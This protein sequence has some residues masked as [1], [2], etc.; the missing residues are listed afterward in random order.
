MA[1]QKDYYDILGVS[2]DADDATIKKAYRQ[3]SKKYHPDLNH[4]EGAEEKFKDI[5]EA[6][7]V[8]SDPQKRAAYD[9]YGSADGPQGFGGGQGFSDFGG[10]GQN[11]G[12]FEDIFSSFFGGGGTQQSAAGPRQ[13]ADLQYRM[14]LKFEE[15]IFGKD[16][17]ISYDREATCHTCGGTGAAP[18]TSPVTC[19]KCHGAGYIQVQRNTPLG[20]MMTREVCDVC[21]GTGKEIKDKCPTCHGTGHEQ[22]RHE[23]DVK[24]PAG[25]EDGQQMRL[26]NAGEAGSNGG[27]YGDL[28]IVFRVAPSDK[29]ERDGATIYLKFPISFAQAALGD[30]IKVD[31]VHG[32]VELKIPAGTQTGSKFRLRGKGA[33]QLRGNGTGDQIVTVEVNT[34]KNLNAKQKEALMSFAAASGDDITPHEGSLFDR[35]KDAF[36]GKQ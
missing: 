29:Y 1:E 7:Q 6:Y 5:N 32:P 31:T 18:G 17:K 35:V 8:L 26:Q 10:A 28:Y 24:V 3:L 19:H 14:D 4:E 15:A 22:E 9:Q 27:G 11:F 34:P 23:I 30:E 12:G 13:G 25:V 21:G 33:P 20:A 36:K 16:T 2:R